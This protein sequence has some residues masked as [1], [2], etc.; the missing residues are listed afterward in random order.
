MWIGGLS[1]DLN[2]LAKGGSVQ[3]ADFTYYFAAS[4][5]ALNLGR[6]KACP[7]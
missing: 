3:R 5:C 6:T 7:L 4:I 1:P 2:D